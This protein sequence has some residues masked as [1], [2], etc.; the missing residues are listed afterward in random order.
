MSDPKPTPKRT[1]ESETAGTGSLRLM[2]EN[3][4]TTLRTS[5]SLPE[6]ATNAP[7]DLVERLLDRIKKI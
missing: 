7:R 6:S 3:S 1:F 2:K 4:Q 5:E